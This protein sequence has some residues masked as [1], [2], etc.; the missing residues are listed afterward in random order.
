MRTPLYYFRR[1]FVAA[2]VFGLTTTGLSLIAQER[3]R[4][5]APLSFVFLPLRST[6]Q[7]DATCEQFM[8]E[9]INVIRMRGHNAVS[10][11]YLRSIILDSRF[12][13]LEA[14]TTSACMTELVKQVGT[15]YVMHGTLYSDSSSE[16]VVELHIV[17]VPANAL[18]S[19]QMDSFNKN[20]QESA[21]EIR[22][23]T[24]RILSDAKK[25]EAKGG[26]SGQ[27]IQ[28]S[29]SGTTASAV[30][31]GDQPEVSDSQGSPETADTA[32]TDAVNS[33][34]DSW[35]Q[36]LPEAQQ[37]QPVEPLEQSVQSPAVE[38]VGQ[39]GSL[40]QEV[41]ATDDVTMQV[42]SET[43]EPVQ[44][45]SSIAVSSSDVEVVELADADTLESAD[46]VAQATAVAETSVDTGSENEQS[47]PLAFQA[48]GPSVPTGALKKDNRTKIS[49]RIRITGFGVA[50]LCGITG[51]IVT[52]SKVKENLKDEKV[53][54]KNYMNASAEQT[55]VAYQQY[56]NKT[57]KTDKKMQQR[58]LLYVLSGLGLAACGISIKF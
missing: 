53:L 22:E 41:P 38:R 9:V 24:D 28:N 58:N 36:D 47:S 8:D 43:L 52:N 42:E 3:S 23:F 15:R 17:D 40:V 1:M 31:S 44:Q 12:G 35:A 16:L 37:P 25:S 48:E 6:Q 19:V 10:T 57:E 51:G 2:A 13:S 18:I 4:D 30:S 46:S 56:I 21:A 26:V 54:F 39:S 32:G 20:L 5:T 50:A 33:L 45:D 34:P 49:K 14:C 55:G 29:S 11:R 27:T 7:L